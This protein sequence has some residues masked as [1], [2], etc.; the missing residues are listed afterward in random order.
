L[1]STGPP[2]RQSPRLLAQPRTSSRDRARTG[3]PR[4]P[5]TQRSYHRPSRCQGAKLQKRR[6]NRARRTLRTSTA[7]TCFAQARQKPSPMQP[8]AR[9]TPP[10]AE[11]EG[12]RGGYRP[13]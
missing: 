12:R 13:C 9:C 3:P 5:R 6:R 4:P 7:T 1:S 8:S 11:P 2:D 10:A